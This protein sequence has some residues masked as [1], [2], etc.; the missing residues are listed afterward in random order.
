MAI[1]AVAENEVVL[2]E[3][4][5]FVPVILHEGSE[6][7]VKETIEDVTNPQLLLVTMTL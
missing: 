4:I 7:T 2:P 1:P 3:Q 5:T 6:F